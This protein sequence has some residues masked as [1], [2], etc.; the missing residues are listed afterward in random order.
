MTL[1]EQADFRVAC[2]Y[3]DLAGVLILYEAYDEASLLLTHA[4]SW[5]PS[6]EG[7]QALTARASEAAAMA[8]SDPASVTR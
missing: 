4:A 8:T 6:A 7:K 2:G 1:L 3:A 5:S